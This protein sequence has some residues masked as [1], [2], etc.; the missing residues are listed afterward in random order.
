MISLLSLIAPTSCRSG[1]D[2][3]MEAFWLPSG[4]LGSGCRGTI[5]Q[6]VCGGVECHWEQ[7]EWDPEYI[8]ARRG[9]KEEVERL[10][11]PEARPTVLL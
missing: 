4:S 11:V 8:S 9:V 3:H 6:S 1:S 7:A 5:P 10:L 2:D